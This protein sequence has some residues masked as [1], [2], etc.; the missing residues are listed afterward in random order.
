[1][2]TGTLGEELDVGN[3]TILDTGWAAPID[4]PNEA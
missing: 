1:M 2:G 4:S 3:D